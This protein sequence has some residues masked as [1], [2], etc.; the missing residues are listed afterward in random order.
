MPNDD[1]IWF[2]SLPKRQAR[3]RAPVPGEFTEAWRLLGEHHSSRRHVLVWRVPQGNPGR[4]LIP[5]GLMR[6]PFLAFADEAIENTDEVVLP[7]LQ[8]LM[9][10]AAKKSDSGFA[11]TGEPERPTLDVFPGW[12]N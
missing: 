4:A 2:R 8:S 5:D 3:I 6:I 11:L 7:I 12:A 10:D 9:A 1:V